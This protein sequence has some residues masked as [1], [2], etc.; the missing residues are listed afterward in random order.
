MIRCTVIET[1]KHKR[2]ICLGIILDIEYIKYIL[3]TNLYF[4]FIRSYI[5]VSI[6]FVIFDMMLCPL[7]W[8]LNKVH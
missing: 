6:Y 3:F 1:D 7:S 4:R 8:S 5:Y 2:I